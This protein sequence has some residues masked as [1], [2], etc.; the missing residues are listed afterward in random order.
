MDNYRT[1]KQQ[2]ASYLDGSK[3]VYAITMKL[4]TPRM[5]TRLEGTSGFNK[6]RE[7]EDAVKLISLIKGI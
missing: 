5:I 7:D 2:E 4:C 6:A 1:Q 3:R